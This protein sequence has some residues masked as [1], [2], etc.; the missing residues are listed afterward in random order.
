MCASLLSNLFQIC[1]FDFALCTLQNLTTELVI[2]KIVCFDGHYLCKLHLLQCGRCGGN[3][4][5]KSA[6]LQAVNCVSARHRGISWISKRQFWMR[7]NT[8][9]TLANKITRTFRL[10]CTICQGRRW[11]NFCCFV[12]AFWLC[13]SNN[14]CC[15]AFSAAC[16][17]VQCSAVHWPRRRCGREIRIGTTFIASPQLLQIQ[18]G[19]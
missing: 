6:K 19:F 16:T 3:D 8:I 14:S 5:S 13:E 1:W 2:L 10:I 15:P 4:K 7:T 11:S 12:N 17:A 9:S 18:L